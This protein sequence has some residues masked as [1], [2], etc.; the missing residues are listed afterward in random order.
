MGI[1]VARADEID[2]LLV[3]ARRCNTLQAGIVDD[4]AEQH[5]ATIFERVGA[6]WN[7]YDIAGPHTGTLA[8]PGR[9]TPQSARVVFP[10]SSSTN[11]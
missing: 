5:R 9:P 3:G 11:V 2:A 7:A 1:T 8:A 6:F 10:A 4:P